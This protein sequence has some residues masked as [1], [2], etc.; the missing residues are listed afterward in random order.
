MS[1]IPSLSTTAGTELLQSGVVRYT[2]ATGTP[3]VKDAVIAYTRQF[4][5]R[6]VARENVMISA[7]AKQAL[8]VAL[9]ALVN[10]GDEV[11]FPVPH[12]VSYPEMVRIV[13]GGRHTTHCYECTDKSVDEA[14]ILVLNG[15]AKQYAMTGFRL[16]WAV[17]PAVIIKA[18]S[19]IQ[20]H[21]SDGP[22]GAFHCFA[23]FSFFDADSVRLSKRFLEKIRVVTVPGIEFGLEGYQRVGFCGDMKDVREGI[24]R[25]RWLLNDSGA[26][27]LKVG[28]RVFVR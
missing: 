25:L 27:E 26:A 12:R 17:G 6:Q 21:L 7:G 19:N 4:Y 5:G 11:G 10:L 1:A 13:G 14:G 2:P 18:M 16:G 15:V 23:D 9:M 24:R 20:P 28:D 22:D 8:M 3:A